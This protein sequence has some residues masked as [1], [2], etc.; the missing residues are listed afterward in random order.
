MTTP[1][2]MR[3]ILTSAT[4]LASVASLSHS[5]TAQSFDYPDFASV[6]GL[7]QVLTTSNPGNVLRVHELGGVMGDNMGAVWYATPVSVS[8]GFDTTFE[9]RIPPPGSGDG[10]AFVVQNDT[11]PG[12]N[13]MSGAFAIG[14]H[15]SAIG[16]GAFV[17]SGPGESIGNSLAIEID[18]FQ[19]N[20]QPAADPILDPDGNHISIH[21]GGSGEN[22]QK[23]AFSIGRAP[24][25]SLGGVDLNNGSTNTLRV[26]Y[27][28]GTL[29]VFLNGNSIINVPYDF[30]S[31]G[32]WIDSS[33]P[34]G[35]LN[36]IGGTSAYVGFTASGGGSTQA[37]ELLSWSFDSGSSLGTPYCTPANTNSSGGP[38]A[39]SGTSNM[40]VGSGLHL[41][42]TGGPSGQLGYFLV[43]TAADA[44]PTIPLG[45]GLLCLGTGFGNAIGRYNVSGGTLNSVGQFNTSGVLQN[46]VGT[47]TTGTGFDVPTLLPIPG[48]TTITTGSTY[49]FQGWFRDSTAGTGQS[50]S[51]N[52]LTVTF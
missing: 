1:F 41:E 7:N 48:G 9:F 21:T 45:N 20:N 52:A 35:G 28:P 40:G 10:M 44:S 2:S 37:H 38:A 4:L 15:A 32:T 51:T 11:T 6:A 42:M 19:N 26:L 14:R 24:S 13:G 23:E 46:L 34:V 5:A 25:A 29:E 18:H 49:Q 50:N 39:I 8:G 33:T 36:L 30:A 16:Y 3:C 27:V 17:S 43:G 31:G 22:S 47:S 12:Y